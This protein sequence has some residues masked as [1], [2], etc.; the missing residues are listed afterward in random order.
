MN[1]KTLMTTLRNNEE[2]MS[3]FPNLFLKKEPP[4]A[5]F[6]G[7]YSTVCQEDFNRMYDA[8]MNRIRRKIR[9]PADM[10]ISSEQRQILQVRKE[11]SLRLLLALKRP[12][13]SKNITYLRKTATRQ[14]GSGQVEVR[15]ENLT[16][17]LTRPSLARVRQHQN[18]E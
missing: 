16:T 6:W 17:G 8:N 13:I 18:T 3:F 4:S 15:A 9:K 10:I 14:E 5:Y 7:I 2:F 12:G 1:V 11:E